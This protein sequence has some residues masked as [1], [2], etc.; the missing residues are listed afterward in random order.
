[1]EEKDNNVFGSP[2]NPESGL[3]AHPQSL[4]ASVPQ[5]T[6]M[7]VANGGG[8]ETAA[9]AM[10]ATRGS[11]G[12]GSFELFGKKKRGRPRKYDSEGRLTTSYQLSQSAPKTTSA[13][14]FSSKRGRAK[15][16]SVSPY[17]HLFSSFGEYFT[18][19]L[20]C[21]VTSKMQHF[22]P[23][24]Y[25]MRTYIQVTLKPAFSLQDFSSIL[26]LK[27]SRIAEPVPWIKSFVFLLF[28]IIVSF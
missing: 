20:S 9:T 7:E 24:Y 17:S 4:S 3:E 6:N 26:I 21:L 1:M 14:S 23:Q 2:G 28:S 5:V 15:T 25:L 18:F 22:F 16:S 11:G 8:A 27:N 10:A 13:F 19:T 12:Q